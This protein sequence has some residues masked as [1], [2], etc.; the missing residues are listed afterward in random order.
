MA[1]DR[2][3]KTFIAIIFLVAAALVA[4]NYLVSQEPLINWWLPL[5]LL[6]IGAGLGIS[7]WLGTQTTTPVES[8]TTRSG[9]TIH[10]HLP[11]A[12]SH[13]RLPV[14]A[15]AEPPPV[16]E[17]VEEAEEIAADHKSEPSVGVEAMGAETQTADRTPEAEALN[18]SPRYADTQA[19]SDALAASSSV[20]A[21]ESVPPPTTEPPDEIAGAPY[22]ASSRADPKLD[23]AL[24]FINPDGKDNLRV[25]EGVGPKMES[26]L[27]SAGI[28]SFKKLAA[29]SEADIH[30]A[31][32]AA[33]MRFAPSIP[34]WAEQAAYAA[35]GD[36]L[37]LQNFQKTLAGGR[38]K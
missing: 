4:V 22:V 16:V 13:P 31:I 26:A 17:M 18:Q 36:W 30:A 5:L 11:S 37:G 6:I 12:E 19:R 14:S 3:T 23:A 27:V 32:E 20:D 7:A 33:G 29:A 24:R 21:G 2:S 28:D 1:L 15:I 8:D 9:A 10:E 38:K 25:I 35:K 34:T